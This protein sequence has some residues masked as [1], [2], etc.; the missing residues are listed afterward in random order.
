A[1]DDVAWC[2][3]LGPQSNDEARIVPRQ[4]ETDVLAV[5]FGRNRQT[6]AF[7]VTAHR[8]FVSHLAEREECLSKLRLGG[9]EQ[10]PTLVSRLINRAV[11]LRTVRTID[12]SH[13][14]SGRQPLATEV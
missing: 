2:T 7:R 6:E 11:Q 12:A 8:P 9:G 3:C 1:T 5:R 4:D 10:E 13:I 14:V